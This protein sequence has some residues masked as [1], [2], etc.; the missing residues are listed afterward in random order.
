MMRHICGKAGLGRFFLLFGV[1]L[2]FGLSER[3]GVKHTLPVHLLAVLNDQYYFTFAVLP[4]FLF[5]C[6]GVMED[7]TLL[8]LT[9]YGTY[10]RYFFHKWRALSVVA[11]LFWL[12]QMA[13][14]LISGLGLP[15]AGSWPGASGGPWREVFTLLQGI[16]PSPWSAILCCAGQ[17]LLG[18]CLIALTALCLGHFCSRALAVRLLMAFY[19]LAVLW[20]QLPVMSR[21]PFVFLTGFNHWV[22]LLHNLAYPWRLLLTAVTTAVL[23]AGMVWLVTRRWRWRFSVSGRGGKCLASY[24]LRGLFAGKNRLLLIGLILLMTVWTWISKGAPEDSTDWLIRLFA[25]HGTGY[26]YPMGLLMLLTMELL[27]LWP[28]GVFCT[29]VAGER[30]VFLTVRLRRRTGLLGAL[31]YTGLLWI[32]VYGCLLALAAVIPPFLLGFSPD[33]G[34]TAAVVGLKILD[35]AF[36]FLIILSALCVTGQA[37]AGFV[38]V[39]LLH[40]L[41]LLPISWLPAGISSLARLNLLQTGGTIPGAAAAVLLAALS[42]VLILWL[43]SRGIKLLFNH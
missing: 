37:T 11:A 15:C 4:V 31:L 10:G 36:Q 17:I 8:V 28:L 7:D 39:L 23:V 35:V 33:M 12:G 13:A 19:L 14:I 30:S 20:I 9:R 5:L 6:T 21:P 27:P 25:G 1:S 24:Y 2:L 42:L 38:A 34:L 3:V 32:L 26:F 22:F 43:Y 18:Y 40:F 16:F 41:C 29:Q